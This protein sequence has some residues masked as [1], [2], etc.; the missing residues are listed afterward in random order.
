[1]KG[2]D[3]KIVRGNHKGTEGKVTEVYRKKYV[4]HIQ[5]VTLNTQ[6]GK[7]VNIG[8]HPSNVVVTKLNMKNHRKELLERKDR[9]KIGSK[10]KFTEAEVGLKT[11][12]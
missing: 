2:D 3:V 7:T 4:I 8:I 11:V 1:M 9:S 6:N 5:S 12:D 10:G